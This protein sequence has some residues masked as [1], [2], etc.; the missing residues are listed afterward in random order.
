V[1]RVLSMSET[2]AD[3]QSGLASAND[4]EGLPARAKPDPL[5]LNEASQLL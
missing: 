1:G 4:D 5:G 2:Y 3:D